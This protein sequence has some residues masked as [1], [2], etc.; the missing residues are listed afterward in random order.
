MSTEYV[1]L[2]QRTFDEEA[3]ENTEDDIPI[4][5]HEVHRRT[6]TLSAPGL[7][8]MAYEM[9]Y[10][11]GFYDSS[12]YKGTPNATLDRNWEKLV[13]SGYVS[14]PAEAM[15]SKLHKSL[16]Y[17]QLSSEH[18]GEYLGNFEVYHQ[19]HCLDLIRKYTYEDYYRHP[20]RLPLEFTDSNK[21]LRLHVDH[22]IDYLR[23]LIM[24]TGDVG[25]HTYFWRKDRDGPFPDFRVERKCRKWDVVADYAASARGNISVPKKPDDAF[26]YSV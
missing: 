11:D 12:P 16:N 2:K 18:G 17:V 21:T 24:C 25:I 8:H 22:C 13:R 7:S 6:W 9:R 1:A 5:Q 15:E 4:S 10:F 20:D 14:I 19:L 26:E 23:Q 3:S